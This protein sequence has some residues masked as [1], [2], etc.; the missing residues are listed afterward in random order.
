MQIVVAASDKQ[1]EELTKSRVGVEWIRVKNGDEFMNN[2]TAD[3]YFDLTSNGFLQHYMS[4]EKPVII[5]SVVETLQEL[6]APEN[7]LRINGWPGFLQR[8]A[9]EIT[10]IV[11]EHLRTVFEKL[12]IRLH[13]VADKPGLVAARIIAL[14]VNEA[15]LALEDD[16]SSKSEI[17]TAM[18]L[19]TN[20]PF[21][22]FEWSTAIGIEN[23]ATL[24]EKLNQESGRYKPAGL[25]INE[26]IKKAS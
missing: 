8:P 22:P 2:K 3:A 9:W 5:N 19:G 6:N 15:Y 24:L 18:K 12:E 20:Y 4:L 14:I 7:I 1:W 11:D 23:I 17:D 10:G 25:L 16:V 26:V 13:I 21:G